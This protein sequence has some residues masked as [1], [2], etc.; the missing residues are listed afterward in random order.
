MTEQKEIKAGFQIYTQTSTEPGI[1][2]DNDTGTQGWGFGKSQRDGELKSSQKWGEG[3]SQPRTHWDWG[4][5]SQVAVRFPREARRVVK[6]C[7]SI[8]TILIFFLLI[9]LT[10]FTLMVIIIIIIVVIIVIINVMKPE[11]L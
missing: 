5:V 7:L 2:S 3:V 11:D 9:I 6:S 1:G 10:N 4:V 8:K